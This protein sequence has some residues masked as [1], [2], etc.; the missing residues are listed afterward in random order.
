MNTIQNA[1]FN[2]NTNFCMKYK[3]P[4]KWGRKTLQTFMD[5]QLKQDID[6]KYPDA[7]ATYNLKI[8]RVSGLFERKEYCHSLKFDLELKKGKKWTYENSTLNSS[9]LLDDIF[10]KKLNQTT[11]KNI[12]NDIE[13]EENIKITHQ[14]YVNRAKAENKNNKQTNLMYEKIINL[15]FGVR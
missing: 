12:E 11:L 13:K 1:Q 15:L 5:S 2:N 8:K 6:K 4:E 3:S 14:E 7:V 10:S 9:E